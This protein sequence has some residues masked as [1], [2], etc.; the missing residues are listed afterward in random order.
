MILVFLV[1]PSFP[2]VHASSPTARPLF[3]NF[4]GNSL[5]TQWSFVHLGSNSPTLTL[6]NSILRLKGGSD[7]QIATPFSP[8]AVSF[9]ITARVRAHSFDR[10]HIALA[11]KPG[12]FDVLPTAAFELDFSGNECGNQPAAV[13]GRFTGAWTYKMFQCD[14]STESWYRIQMVATRNPW[15]VT[16]NLMDDSGGLIASYAATDM[17]YSYDSIQYVA[18]GTWCTLSG[19]PSDYDV[20]W[21]STTTAPAVPGFQRMY[22]LNITSVY[23]VVSS[24][25]QQ[26]A[27]NFSR[28]ISELAA[29]HGYSLTIINTLDGWD[30]LL[31]QPPQRIIVYSAHWNWMLIP[32]SWQ[33]V[34][35]QQFYV[36]VAGTVSSKG[37]IMH[38]NDW[39]YYTYYREGDLAGTQVGTAGTETFLSF[40]HVSMDAWTDSI[41]PDSSSLTQDGGVAATAA[42]IVLPGMINGPGINNGPGVFNH[43]AV[44]WTGTTPVMAFYQT[45]PWNGGVRYPASAIRM[46]SGF[47]ADVQWIEN[48]TLHTEMVF[49]FTTVLAYN[50]AFEF[51]WADSNNDGQVNILDL[52]TVAICYG[53]T[54][55]STNWAGCKYWDLYQRNK[56]DVLDLA[57]V[58][59]LF[60]LKLPGVPFPGQGLPPGQLDPFWSTPGLCQTLSSTNQSY[61]TANS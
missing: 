15:N 24:S 39:P 40:I 17:A 46:G 51:D 19:C 23:P 48:L 1:H 57:T 41:T 28:G 25:S 36:Y 4:D 31:R 45:A 7:I 18:L 13:A 42:N 61:C 44:L 10:F 29:S 9:Q 12:I 30:N 56:V 32:K 21:I 58:A 59:I 27:V 54:S 14:L 22:L 3:D 38:S 2:T 49:A 55:N 60:D 53:S 5:S 50:V 34:T 11:N 26:W 43:R 35:W 6:N 33:N 52:A 16:W 8:S 47:F 20:D 37:W